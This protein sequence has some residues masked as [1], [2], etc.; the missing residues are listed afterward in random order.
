MK[1]H[2]IT[3]AAMLVLASGC[4]KQEDTPAKPAG[5]ATTGAAAPAPA[6]DTADHVTVLGHHKKP[7]PIDPVHI[8]FE[9]FKVVKADFDPK[10][11]EGGT[12]TIE[13][14]LSSFHTNSDERDNHL[15]SA[16]YID[17]AKFATATITVDNVK[18]KAGTTYTADAS[19][20]AHGMTQKYPVTFDVI[21][22]ADDHIRIKAEHTF[23]RLDFGIGTDPAQN[24][25]EQVAT[26]LTIQMVLTLKKT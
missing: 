14:D 5:S 25:D 18:Q 17:V 1:L 3:L 11:I 21:E 22:S 10:K 15:K 20:S 19:V 13:L 6:A 9:R 23:T 24:G 8:N 12:A 16:A 7:K 4:K 26:D 2:L